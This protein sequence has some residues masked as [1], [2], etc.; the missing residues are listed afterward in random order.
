LR[1]R[2]RITVA[3]LLSGLALALGAGCESS[4]IPLADAPPASQPDPVPLD[5][6]TKGQRP[7]KHSSAEAA[8]RR[9]QQLSGGSSAR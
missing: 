2:S 6:L 8:L 9:Q 7:P 4:D 1:P 3:S 5:K